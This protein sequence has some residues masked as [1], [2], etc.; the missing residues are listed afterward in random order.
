MKNGAHNVSV[1]QMFLGLLLS[2]TS[3]VQNRER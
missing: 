1:T 2:I 3:G